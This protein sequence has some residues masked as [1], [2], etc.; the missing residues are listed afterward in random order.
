MKASADSYEVYVGLDVHKETIAI[1]IANPER[2]GEIRFWGNILNAPTTVQRTFKKLLALHSSM[3]VCYEAG[4]GGYVLYHQLTDMGIKCQVIA[5]SRIPKSPTDRIKNDHRDAVMLAR[6]LRAGE[7][8]EVW[9]PDQH[10]KP[11]AIWSEPV[12]QVK[13]TLR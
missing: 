4:P 13:K 5:P 11:C 1:A 8:V 10:M 6:L 3:L 2:N 7:L 9:V 12:R